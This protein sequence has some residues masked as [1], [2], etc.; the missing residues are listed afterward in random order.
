MRPWMV[1]VFVYELTIIW[2]F[3]V[4]TFSYRLRKI[5]KYFLD[6]LCFQKHIN[7]LYF[8]IKEWFGQR[9]VFSVQS[10][11]SLNIDQLCHLFSDLV[12][13]HFWL[14]HERFE[15]IILVIAK[16]L[17]VIE[18]EFWDRSFKNLRLILSY[19]RFFYCSRFLCFYLRYDNFL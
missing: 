10:P 2:N 17:V 15:V 1:Q 4:Q 11:H 7:P 5:R 14:L 3:A 18:R 6:F 12:F 16:E 19:F 8:V 9:W 13:L